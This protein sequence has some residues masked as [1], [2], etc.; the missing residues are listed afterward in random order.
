MA[1]A[2]LAFGLWLRLGRLGETRLRALLFVPISFIV[3][4]AHTFGWGMLG[5]M[6]FS[7]EAVRQ[8]DRGIGWLQA[9]L[10]AAA[11]AMVMA[12]PALL[13]LLWRSNMQGAESAAWF[14]WKLK[15]EALIGVLRD[16]WPDFDQWSL[17]VVVIAIVYALF[18]RRPP[19]TADQLQALSAGDDFKG[20]DTE[21]A[22]GFR[23]TAFEDAVRESYCDPRYSHV[24]VE[25]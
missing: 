9:G 1:L 2:F 7:A 16:R 5:R 4:F 17:A 12:L 15:F 19:F 11:H 23:Q 22:F 14:I 24:L 13:I 25:R 18:S 20:V 6:A 8:H 3:Y 21:Q 10:R